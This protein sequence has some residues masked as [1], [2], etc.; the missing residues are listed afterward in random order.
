MW[1]LNFIWL[2]NWWKEKTEVRTERVRAEDAEIFL[3]SD[4]DGE[5]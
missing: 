4:K 5:D 2:N 1:V 3:G